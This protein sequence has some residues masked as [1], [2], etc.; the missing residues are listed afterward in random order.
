MPLYKARDHVALAHANLSMLSEEE[1]STG[2]LENSLNLRPVRER[3]VDYKSLEGIMAEPK[4]LEIFSIFVAKHFKVEM[5]YFLLQVTKNCYCELMYS[6]K[7]L[8]N[9]MKPYWLEKHC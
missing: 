4:L 1:S 5:I 7:D 9:W 3:Q 8:R 6:W 2:T